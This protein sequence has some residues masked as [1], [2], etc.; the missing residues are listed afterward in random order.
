MA[1][2]S[3]GSDLPLAIAMGSSGVIAA[4]ATGDAPG[5]TVAATAAPLLVQAAV[6]LRARWAEKGQR[7]IDVA[8]D[9]MGVGVDI[10]LERSLT[11]EDR[12]E[13]LARV[14][15]SSARST[16][17][18]KI[19]ALGRVLADGLQEDGDIAEAL[20]L[21]RALEVLD[22]PHVVVLDHLARNRL[23]PA[24]LLDVRHIGVAGWQV[25]VI[26]EALP[27]LAD[28]MEPLVATLAG[29]GLLRDNTGVNYASQPGPEAWVITSP[30][31]RCLFLLDPEREG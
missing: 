27:D 24:E 20:V 12:L 9:H 2:D 18:E 19:D 29:I 13:L 1:A 15:E 8:A 23:P 25:P 17:E 4:I 21:A 26:A 14:I 5:T 3:P 10:V 30:G 22:Q 31:L 16:F 28:V 6:A 7:A 11:Y